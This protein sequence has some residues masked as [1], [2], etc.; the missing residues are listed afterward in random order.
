MKGR[1]YHLQS[2][3]QTNPT[4]TPTRP[5]RRNI[6]CAF[7][8]PERK[9]ADPT[10]TAVCPEAVVVLRHFQHALRLARS[11]SGKPGSLISPPTLRIARRIPAGP[12]ARDAA[13]S[14]LQTPRRSARAMTMTVTWSSSPDGAAR[15]EKANMRSRTNRYPTLFEALIITT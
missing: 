1:A 8:C 14:Q 2:S 5:N 4:T 11:S 9:A 12:G 7:Q 6:A 10:R 3:T 13:A 15:R